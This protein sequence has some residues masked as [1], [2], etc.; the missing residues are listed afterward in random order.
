MKTSGQDDLIDMSHG[1]G[2][3]MTSRIVRDLFIKAYGNAYLRAGGDAAILPEGKGQLV[4]STDSH[5]VAPLFFPGGDIGRLAICGTVNDVCT[6]GAR[7]LYLSAGFILEEGLPL[8]TLQ[9]VVASMAEAAQEAGVTI[10]TGD[11]KVVERGKCDGLFIN[12]TGVGIIETLAF[13]L[14]RSSI[15][16]GDKI[17]INGPIGNHGMAVMAA[18]QGISSDIVSDVAPLNGLVHHL[19]SH[20]PRLHC[21]TDPTRGGVAAVLNEIVADA[22]FG[23]GLFE[24]ALP[25]DPAVAAACEL[26]GMDP[27][28]VANEGKMLFFCPPED[29][30]TALHLLQQHECGKQAAI[31]GEV[32]GDNQGYVYARTAFGGSHP[33]PW[34]SGEQMP[35]IC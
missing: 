24:T 3:K 7:P 18:R 4:I 34:L 2:G 17:L 20:L 12:T 13:N 19:M 8:K 22:A 25:V 14:S 35:R 21:M 6:A 16:I 15:R 29:S 26:F 11:T 10:V 28:H 9:R 1:G 27:L 32:T 31:I 23:I 33:V 30:D 5:V